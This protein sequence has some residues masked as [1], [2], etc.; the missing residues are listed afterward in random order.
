MA[1]HREALAV[2]ILKD[3]F[4]GVV[5]QVGQALIS[6]GRLTLPL[7]ARFSLLKLKDVRESVF[8]LMQQNLVQSEED[9]DGRTARVSVIYE[10]SVE[11]VLYR[12]FFP[13]FIVTAQEALGDVGRLIA[14]ALLK[15]GKATEHTI[16]GEIKATH[17]DTTQ[18]QFEN[19]FNMFHAHDYA[20]DFQI[21]KLQKEEAE[22]KEEKKRGSKRQKLEGSTYKIT[23]TSSRMIS[24]DDYWTLNYDK[25]FAQYR[26][27]F[28]VEFASEKINQNAGIL[29]K[30]IFLMSTVPLEQ[31]A[32]P[33]QGAT[34][35]ALESSLSASTPNSPEAKIA[36]H[37]R[38]Y[39]ETLTRDGFLR[40]TDEMQG[41]VYVPNI[42]QTVDMLKQRIIESNI[43][44]KYGHVSKRIYRLLVTRKFVDQKQVAQ[45][46]MV[47]VEQ[48]REKL[49]RMHAD[50]YTCLQE[51]P[52]GSERVVAKTM[53]FWSV[54]EKHVLTKVLDDTL[55]T[56]LN[57]LKRYSHECSLC[58]TLIEKAAI[59]TVELTTLEQQQLFTLSR[60]LG[61][62]DASQHQL[63]QALLIY[64]CF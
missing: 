1:S 2:E 10:I 6:H 62:L 14:E 17:P 27:E 59:E 50:G 40:K 19:S 21:K 51:V 28:A 8:I 26:Q 43:N 33:S 34:F 49:Y 35:Y 31:G 7:I 42:S 36:A 44:E 25:F 61:R 54:N 20:K 56:M 32:E 13:K 41:G 18:E 9:V 12:L 30:K 47:H 55:K 46:A 22:E 5:S 29:L 39:L 57:I 38:D 24:G 58:E 52:K 45:I 63:L 3:H 37:L 11:A 16:L 48:A 60:I 53:F 4:G 15:H 23:Y 64:L